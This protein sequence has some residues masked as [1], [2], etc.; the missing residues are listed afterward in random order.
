[1]GSPVLTV[2]NEAA[3]SIL[4]SG[5]S[6]RRTCPAV[7]RDDF[8]RPDPKVWE[9]S[10]GWSNEQMFNCG[11]MADNI[12]FVKDGTNEV[13]S[14]TLNDTPASGKPY[15]SGEYRTRTHFGYGLIEA[16]MKAAKGNGVI[17]SVFLCTGPWDE[18]S[19]KKDPWDEID[20]EILGNDTTKMQINY[21]TAGM[22]GKGGHQKLIALGFD[23]S[24]DFHTYAI[25]WERTHII[26][27]VDGKI[28]HIEDGKRGEL[29][30]HPGR[31]IV[32]LWPG[33][34]VDGWCGKFEYR[35][36][37]KASYDWIKYTPCEN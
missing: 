32:N 22:G 35:S 2:T 8:C 9:R 18:I 7:F 10:D 3:V 26:W 21:I 37:L 14:I 30:T 36:P 15:S 17:S 33:I 1:M 23:A 24:K 6:S 20:I 11:W 19:D 5:I 16:R 12:D 13:M 28:S 34:G 27:F 4:T 31:I 29:P 25:R